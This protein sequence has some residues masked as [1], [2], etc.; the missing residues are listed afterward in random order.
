LA[1]LLDPLA[2]E[3]RLIVAD[4]LASA[5]QATAASGMAPRLRAI[6]SEWASISDAVTRRYFALLPMHATRD[7]V[8]VP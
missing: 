2:A 3:T 7:L 8:L 6:E 1:I 5:D 4:L